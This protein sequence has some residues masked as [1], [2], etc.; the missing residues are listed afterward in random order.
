MGRPTGCL[1]GA[2]TLWT[3]AVWSP[4]CWAPTG[5]STTC[6][7]GLP[8][9]RTSLPATGILGLLEPPKVWASGTWSHVDAYVP[10]IAPAI[11]AIGGSSYGALYAVAGICAVIG[12]FAVL[13]VKRVR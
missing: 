5:V 9:T 12:A 13:P 1:D 8:G 11:L 7:V 6:P 10:A 3:A 2:G 4:S